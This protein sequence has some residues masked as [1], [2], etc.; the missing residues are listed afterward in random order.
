MQTVLITFPK[1]AELLMRS[2]CTRFISW[3]KFI[4]FQFT[5]AISNTN[6]KIFCNQYFR[7]VLRLHFNEAERR[8]YEKFHGGFESYTFKF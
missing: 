2:R 6:Y 5:L 1:S 7:K 3:G 4:Y 8:F